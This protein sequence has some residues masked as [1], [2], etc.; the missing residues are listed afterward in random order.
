MKRKLVICSLEA[1]PKCIMLPIH[2]KTTDTMEESSTEAMVDTSA[3]RDFIDQDFIT[4]AKLPTCKLSQPIP[5]YNVD[6]TPNEAG[7]IHEVVDV[8]MTYNQHLERILL[9]VT[10]LGKQSMILG[11]TWL[12]KHNPEID[13]RTRSVKMTRCL[14]RCCIGC[15]TNR[16]AERSVKKEDTACI[17]TCQMGP[18]PAFV[19]DADEE[20]DDSKCPSDTER[21]SDVEPDDSDE[22]L[23]EGDHIWAMGLFPQAE[24][25]RASAMVSQRLTEG[26]RQNF[27]PADHEKHIPEHLCHFHSV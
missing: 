19:E 27:Q 17:N 24:H 4:H 26:F 13:F 22:P 12:D 18:F 8:I 23:E 16:K 15:Q 10:R 6:G 14:P 9:T 3:T 21:P 7:S 2:L 25:I 5:V 1:G 11:F 20:E